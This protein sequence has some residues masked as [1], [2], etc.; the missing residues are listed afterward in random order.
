ML[1]AKFRH[2]LATISVLRFFAE[3]KHLAVMLKLGLLDGLHYY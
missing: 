2:A 1:R 3:A